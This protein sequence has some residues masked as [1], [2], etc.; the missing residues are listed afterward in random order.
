MKF[1]SNPFT[2]AFTHEMNESSALLRQLWGRHYIAFLNTLPLS[3]LSRRF[4]RG[5]IAFELAGDAPNGE[6]VPKGTIIFDEDDAAFATQEDVYVT[7]AALQDVFVCKDG[8]I[9][10]THISNEMTIYHSWALEDTGRKIPLP[11]EPD[12]INFSPEMLSIEVKSE[13]V[14]DLKLYRGDI[15]VSDR[16][17][18]FGREFIPQ[19]IFYI[20]SNDAFGKKGAKVSIAFALEWE[21]RDGVMIKH[22]H[23]DSYTGAIKIIDDDEIETISIEKISVEYYN[24]LDFVTLNTLSLQPL[25]FICPHDMEILQLNGIESRWLRVRV[26][27]TTPIPLNKSYIFKTP[28][29]EGVNISYELE[30]GVLPETVVVKNN[31]NTKIM[32]GEEVFGQ[33]FEPFPVCEGDSALFLG[34]DKPFGGKPVRALVDEKHIINLDDEPVK[35]KLF[36]KELYWLKL[37]ETPFE[38]F[39]LNAVKII[40]QSNESARC[41]WEAGE[42]TRLGASLG[43][44]QKASNPFEVSGGRAEEPPEK[45]LERGAE[46]LR[47]RDRA[48]TASDFEALAKKCG[49]NLKKCRAFGEAGKVT[50]LY[51]TENFPTPD[52]GIADVIRDYLLERCHPAMTL[53]ER[54]TVKEVEF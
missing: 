48:V 37:N 38:N 46:I 44:V 19:D 23:Y 47:H 36:G 7:N 52:N 24:G 6:F 1:K 5:Y 40:Q 9:N 45:L 31:L 41:T 35:Q 8:K 53:P 54:L 22:K 34:F 29:I 3:P 11:P 2:H 18:P 16:F 21:E 10:D 25:E 51:M 49:V 50:V 15:E 43:Y 12:K 27:E 32:R 42:I 33:L 26:T 20:A 17:Y 30:G 4:A 28:V 14:S 13:S 39:I